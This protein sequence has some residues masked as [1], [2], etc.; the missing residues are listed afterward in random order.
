MPLELR[1]WINPQPYT[2]SYS[3]AGIA[4][5]ASYF[6][7]APEPVDVDADH[8]V[9][10]SREYE[11]AGYD[12]SII[13]A[14]ATWPDVAAVAG[15]AL[16]ATE[17]LTVVQ[18]H[19]PGI[20]A[21]SAAA[22]AL[23]TLDRL[24]GGRTGIHLILG[25]SDLARDGD[26]LGREERYA[27]AAEYL[28]VYTRT[29]TSVEPFDFEGEYYRVEGAFSGVRPLGTPRPVISTPGGSAEGIELGARY[30]DVLATHA[31]S[32]AEVAE[33]IDGASARAAGHDRRLRYWVN[34]NFLV[35][36]TDEAAWA[37]ARDL[38]QA[39]DVLQAH[40]ARTPG[41]PVESIRHERTARFGDVTDPVVDTCL[42]LG[43]VRRGGALPTLVG[44]P[45][46]VADAVL[47]YYD[48][49]V[50]IVTLGGLVTNPRDAE[51]RAETLRLAHQGALSRDLTH[52][53]KESR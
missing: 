9:A 38:E 2:N 33:W 26:H 43:F 5:E 19:R 52:P 25:H 10:E 18:A 48:L 7:T 17:R 47:A 14:S 22:R 3:T 23:A 13:P 35:G 32:L 41:E 6:S 24:S 42:H 15:W 28:E 44:S 12:A 31:G 29:L 11:A 21:P 8:V 37:H 51:L 16:A 20:Q 46:T 49:G 40:R 4:R 53:Q 36:E 1:S 27:R 39:V 50:E 34:A 30:A 45:S